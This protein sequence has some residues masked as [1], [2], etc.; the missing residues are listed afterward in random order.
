MPSAR[1]CTFLSEHESACCAIQTSMIKQESIKRTDFRTCTKVKHVLV[2]AVYHAC[3]VGIKFFS[4]GQ[5]LCPPLNRCDMPRAKPDSFVRGVQTLTDFFL[6][7]EGRENPNTTKR[8]PS[9]A[10]QRNAIAFPWRVDDGPTLNAGY[11]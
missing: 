9:S 2:S 4:N 5:L 7:A 10:S 3:F 8:G 6:V 1:R 11:V